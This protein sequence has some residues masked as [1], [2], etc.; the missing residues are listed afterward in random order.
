MSHNQWYQRDPLLK[1]LSRVSDQGAIRIVPVATSI[2]LL[3]VLVPGAIVSL[4]HQNASQQFLSLF[5]KRELILAVYAYFLLLPLIWAFYVWQLQ[6][7]SHVIHMLS[8]HG[9]IG[10]DA[11]RSDLDSFGDFPKSL[12]GAFNRARNLGI[13]SAVPLLFVTAWWVFTLK[14]QQVL[15]FGFPAIWWN[16]NPLFF[17]VV[18]IP[19]VL[20]VAY[21][22]SWIVI[23]QVIAVIG[24]KRLF[25]TYRLLPKPFHPDK[26][27]GLAP[28]GDYAIR[29]AGMAIPFGFWL[30][31]LIV[32]PTFFG[33]HIYLDFTTILLLLIYTIAVPI[34]LISPV[35]SAH[36][37]MRKAKATA[38]EDIATQL[39]IALAETEFEVDK[40]I[41]ERLEGLEKKYRIVAQEYQTWPFDPAT[42]KRFS[43][44]S[45]IPSVSTIISYVLDKYMP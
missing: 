35:W 25:H 2:H 33:E 18:F 30:M 4:H 39:R 6:G 11:D 12:G 42:V 9:V 19:H 24:F 45:A 13:V 32:Y 27:N 26:A 36:V 1:L 29:S 21:L 17:W 3:L 43:I 16:V 15:T 41:V 10:E 44:T 38:L 40:R 7:I 37:A 34:L 5:D 20:L 22:I 28:L 31:L 8:E 23:R 14:P